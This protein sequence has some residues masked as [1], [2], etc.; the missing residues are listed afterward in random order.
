MPSSRRKT[1]LGQKTALILLGLFLGIAAL[2]IGLR[3]SGFIILSLQ[4]RAN[5]LSLLEKGEY[6]ILCLGESTTADGGDNSYPRWLE[7]I[8]N[9]ELKEIKFS[10]INKGLWASNS[11]AIVAGLKNNLDTYKPDLVITMMGINDGPGTEAYQETDAGRPGFSLWNFRVYKLAQLLK[12]QIRYTIS[13]S[14]DTPTIETNRDNSSDP[15]ALRSNNHSKEIDEE[16]LRKRIAE[17]PYD[18]ETYLILGERYFN[19]GKINQAAGIYERATQSDPTHIQACEKLAITY[20]RLGKNLAAKKIYS[21]L[22]EH[23]PASDYL[24]LQLGR[25]YHRGIGDLARAEEAYQETIALNPENDLARSELGRL[26]EGQ[27]RLEEA[28]K[29][30][31]DAFTTNPFS[32]TAIS[33]LVFHYLRQSKYDAAEKIC[34]KIIEADP[35]YERAY[36]GLALV[37]RRQGKIGAAEETLRKVDQLNS[38]FYNPGTV[39]NYRKLREILAG[40]E[41]PLICVQYPIFKVNYLRKI[42][43]DPEE[44]IFVDNEEVFKEA[45]RRRS[46]GDLFTDQFAGD[47]GHCTPEGYRLLAG[48]IAGVIASK[49]FGRDLTDPY[50][51]TGPAPPA[52]ATADN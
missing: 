10:V 25:L 38:Q 3:L 18:I 26:Y 11:G 13:G 14:K 12:E 9:K 28:I 17:N 52:A 5:R 4:E 16:E 15:R 42:F 6:V 34:Q 24:Y 33:R 27:G 47:F 48:N 51:Q 41:I 43:L 1:T 8:L 20:Q 31:E 44:I 50:R 35:N 21:R 30:Y 36:R 19:A 46:Y 23:N 32:M 29:Q 22:I 2:E 45:L 7:R 40:R 37:Y 49:I 39:R